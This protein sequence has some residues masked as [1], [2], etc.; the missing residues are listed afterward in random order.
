MLK[1]DLILKSPVEKAIGVENITKGQLGA[2]LSRAGVGKTSFL[3]QI[4][5]TQLLADQKILHVSLDDPMDKINLR[6]DEAYTNLVDNI[7]YVDPQ[8]AV[9]LWEDICPN[10]VGISYTESTFNTDK[11]REYLKSFKKSDIA[12]PTILVID[13]LNFDKD[14]SATLKELK[15]LNQEFGIFI[16]FSIKSHRDEAWSQE[17]FPVQL[18]AVKDMFDKAIFLK[19]VEDKI[20]AVILKDGDRM[21]QTYRLE[22]ATMMLVE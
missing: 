4:A 10:K 8:K 7:G 22:P 16:W 5:L 15:S 14:V 19:P 21:N 20:E 2:V 12:L 18:E 9:R 3:V 11:I 17:G 1:K 6:Y 13:G